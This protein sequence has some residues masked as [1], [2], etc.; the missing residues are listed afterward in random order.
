MYAGQLI[1]KSAEI[2]KATIKVCV[3]SGEGM[4]ASSSSCIELMVALHYSGLFEFRSDDYFILSKG[5]ATASYY[6][7][8]AD[9]GCFPKSELKNYC[10]KGILQLHPHVGIPGVEFNTGSLGH[11]LPYGAGLAL[12]LKLQGDSGRVVVLMGDAECQE[13]TTWEAAL[14][15]NQHNLSN[16][17]VVI[18]KN[19]LGAM[20]YVEDSMA[21]CPLEDKFEA[22][23]WNVLTCNGHDMIDI[24]ASLGNMQHKRYWENKP[25]VLIANTVKGKGIF[26]MENNPH[27]H[28]MKVGRDDL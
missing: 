16:L 6:N 13:G 12:G 24:I 18:D 19:R 21:V 28:L 9:L 15:A 8:L 7:I 22:F 26:R 11:G 17:L 4:F 27:A 1:R 25:F 14:F 20:G 23:G 2:R 3:E 5:H 10:K